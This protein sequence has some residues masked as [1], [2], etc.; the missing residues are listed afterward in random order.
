M[1]LKDFNKVKVAWRNYYHN[2]QARKV[3]RCIEE[4]K[5]KIKG[6]D[7]TRCDQYAIEVLGD[8][9]YSPWLQVYT[10]FSGGFKEGW[11]PDNYYSAVVVP[12]LKGGYGEL[13]FL[14]PLNRMLFPGA[15]FPDI[16]YV[17]NGLVFDSS[18][19]SPLSSG[20]FYKKLSSI[21]CG[22]N[23]RAVVF[24]SDNSKQGAGVVVFLEEDGLYEKLL[25][26]GNGVVQSYIEQHGFFS[27]FT[28]NSTATLR[29]T[30]VYHQTGCVE[31][32]AAYLRLAQPFDTHVKSSSH[33]RVPVDLS[34]GELSRK[35]Y[36]TNWCSIDTYPGSSI[37]FSGKII[38]NFKKC[39]DTVVNMHRQ[40]PYA[41]VIGWDVIVNSECDV[42]IIE[43][44]GAHN[45][46]KFSE[47]SQGPCFL[48]LNWEGLSSASLTR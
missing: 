45:D 34:S 7:K 35:G 9:K 46:I 24:K 14:S 3:L 48:G 41:R 39:L 30:T 26:L 6:G 33:I 44:N 40:Y 31:V 47:A 36:L 11:I 17:V 20:D 21:G 18:T 22:K 23:G 19:I 2:N 37:N 5:G 25:K 12:A 29:L 27:E 43:W 4:D 1:S 32:H 8:K 16:F 42:E 13:E 28:P 15:P 38:P 10:V